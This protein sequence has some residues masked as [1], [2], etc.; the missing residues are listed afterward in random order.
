M[1]TPTEARRIQA[2]NLKPSLAQ[3]E[4]KIDAML[5]KPSTSGEWWY[6]IREDGGVV[7]A[8][9]RLYSLHWDVQIGQ[10]ERPGDLPALVFKVRK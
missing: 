3:H 4:I 7:D 5:C 9:I 1:I 8:I 2:E 10:Q 6:S